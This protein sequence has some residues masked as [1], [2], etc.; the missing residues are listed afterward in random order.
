M[1]K[2]EI[3]QQKIDRIGETKL[4]NCG[5]N[6]TI[7]EYINSDNIVVQFEDG[8]NLK[9][10]YYHFNKREN[11]NPNYSNKFVGMKNIMNCGMKCKIIKYNNYDNIEFEFEDGAIVNSTYYHFTHGE[12]HNPNLRIKLQRKIDLTNE[13]IGLLTV[14]GLDHEEY[15]N[16][17]R[18]FFW[19]CQCEC[20][21]F[22][23]KK[24]D[25]LT[26][27]KKD[28]KKCSCGCYNTNRGNRIYGSIKEEIPQYIKYLKNKNDENLSLKSN[29][30]I[31]LVCQDCGYEKEMVVSH[32]TSRGFVCPIC[33][34]YGISLGERYVRELLKT[35]DIKFKREKSFEWSNSRRYD[36]YLIDYNC[37]IEIN[38]IQHY[39]EKWGSWKKNSR[40]LKEE[41]KN[42]IYKEKI[43]KENG[44]D[45]YIILEYSKSG[46]FEI[47]NEVKSKLTDVLNL[48]DFDFNLLLYNM[49]KSLTDYI[50]D[51]WN[52]ESLKSVSNIMKI[53]HLS[54]RIVKTHLKIGTE[55]GLCS[56]SEEDINN[57]HL[58]INRKEVI[59]N[60]L[61]MKFKSMT[62]CNKYIKDNFGIE[63][64]VWIISKCCRKEK[65]N[66]SRL[67]GYTF[68]YV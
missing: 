46:Y 68:D 19:K 49:N 61:N 26:R 3:E 43:A 67:Y 50:C 12:I 47:Q 31:T 66:I 24:Q 27:H 5:Q 23:I 54:R 7:I 4:M 13:K 18:K 41:Q 6:A 63:I 51:I 25:Y 10:S 59:C 52:K 1:T 57:E 9:T 44:I 15:I 48:Q 39:K 55:K 34:D 29:K 16:N 40:S 28:N 37:I 42:D 35:L 21:N 58:T 20:G 64:D 36:F 38:G 45:L 65:V 53:T 11:K 8:T 14:I 2:K 56:Y 62:E 22:V 60:E 32:F 33:G 30:K 17:H